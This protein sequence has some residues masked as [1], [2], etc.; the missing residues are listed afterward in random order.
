MAELWFSVFTRG[1]LR[2]GDFT[3]RADLIEK[4]TN[5]TIRYNRTAKPFT[6]TYDA[7]A[8]HTR[9]QARY[10]ARHTAQHTP[11]PASNQPLTLAA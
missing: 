9:Y 1:L 5:F 8:D 3:S 2:R 7:H 11:A 4:I 10:Q 6:W